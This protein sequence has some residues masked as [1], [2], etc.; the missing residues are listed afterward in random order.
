MEDDDLL[1]EFT[2]HF[3]Q[4]FALLKAIDRGYWLKTI[5]YTIKKKD[6][7]HGNKYVVE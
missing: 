3:P 4:Q 5:K 2:K 6:D 7:K 1:K